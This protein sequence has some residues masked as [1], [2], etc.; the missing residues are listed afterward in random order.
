M[1]TYTS[2]GLKGF[3]QIRALRLEPEEWS[4]ETGYMTPS[5]KLKRPALKTKY[6]KDVAAMYKELEGQS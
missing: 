3:E 6:T 1:L 5:L 2:Q 4:V